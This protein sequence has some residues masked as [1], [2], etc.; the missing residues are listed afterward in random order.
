MEELKTIPDFPNYAITRDGRVWSKPRRDSLNRLRGGIWIKHWKSRIGYFLCPLYQNNKKVHKLVHR[1]VLE[2]FVGLCPD[3]MEACHNNGI[4]TDNRLSNLRWDTKS[5]NQRDSIK[6]GTH[7]TLHQN[8]E[9]NPT[10][11]L[12]ASDIKVI[13]YLYKVVNFLQNDIAWH[14]NISQQHVSRIVNR[15]EWNH[16]NA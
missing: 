4:R 13:Q 8:G 14:F 16:I 7:T 1:L 5:S 15:K 2:T 10:S 11:K 9:T 12:N 6:H 3:G